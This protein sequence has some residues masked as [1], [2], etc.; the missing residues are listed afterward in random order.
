MCVLNVG[1]VQTEMGN[2]AAAATGKKEA[3]VTVEQSVGGIV[4]LLDESTR[5]THSGRFWNAIDGNELPW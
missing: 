1:W 2:A 5:A 4:K 3:P